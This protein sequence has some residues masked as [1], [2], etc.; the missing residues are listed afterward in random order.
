MP[1]PGHHGGMSGSTDL[2]EAV[3]AGEPAGEPSAWARRT[4]AVGDVHLAVITAGPRDGPL[5]LL[6]HGFPEGARCWRH[7][8]DALARAGYRVWAPDQRGYGESDKPGPVSAYRLDRL[9]SDALGLLDAA[10][11]ARAC[12]V[13]HDWG[14]AVAWWMAQTA[15][16]RIERLVIL[17]C[18]HPGVMRRALI[19][20][21]RQMLRSWYIAL[22]QLPWLPEALASFAEHRLLCWGLTSSSRDATF[23]DADLQAYRTAWRRPGALRAMLHWYR[24]LRLRLPPAPAGRIA[25]PTLLLWGALDRALGRELAGP[26]VDRCEQGRLV[27]L[28]QASHWLQHEEPD[29]VNSLILEHLRPASR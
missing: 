8:I 12:V 11:S 10:G 14:G 25:V 24:A 1:H 27:F 20:R 5:L 15:P 9:V 18:P 7:Q 22:F 3:P 13:G 4:V 16:E 21:P 17:N 2:S 28:D 6:L 29:R 23:T 19:T 26:S